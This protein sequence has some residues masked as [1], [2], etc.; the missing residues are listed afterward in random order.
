MIRE[1]DESEVATVAAVLGL[2]RLYQGD[3]VYLVAWD[4]ETPLGHVHLT[5]G[6]PPELQDVQVAEAHRRRG[7][8]RALIEDAASRCRARGD[9]R[10]RVEVSVENDA[11]RAHYGALGFRDAGIAPRRVVGTVEIRTGTIEVDDTLLTLE[12]PLGA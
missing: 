12:R 7:V 8:A 1:L 10:L 11:A 3:G 9:D 6:E 2:A 4:G 5:A